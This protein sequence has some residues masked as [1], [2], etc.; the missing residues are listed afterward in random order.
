MTTRTK[1][2]AKFFLPPGTRRF[3][4]AKALA[5]KSRLLSPPPPDLKYHEW[6]KQTEPFLWTKQ[7]DLENKPLISIIVP[8]FNSPARYLL[9]MVYSVV[10][11]KYS[12]WELILINASTNKKAANLTR[13]CMQIDKRI[14]VFDTSN[15][16]GIVGN[17]N[18]GLSHC[19]GKYVGL[20]DHDDTLSPEALY[21]VACLLQTQ[22]N[23]QMIYS[24]EDKITEDGE[25]RFD[26][27][28]KPDWSPTL[29]K[30]V[31]YMNHFMV[32]EKKLIDEVGGLRFGFDGAQDYDLY[33]RIIDKKVRVAHV[34]KI[35]YHWRAAHNSTAFNFAI[36]KD[37]QKAGARAV[38]EHLKRNGQKGKAYYRPNLP[39][40]YDT[41]YEPEKGVKAALLLLPGE[42]NEQYAHLV[43]QI[44]RNTEIKIPIDVFVAE[45]AYLTS[46][47]TKLRRPNPV[48]I[49]KIQNKNGFI[50]NALKH[51]NAN[52]VILI[53]CA[54]LPRTGGWIKKICGILTQN[55]G[56]GAIAPILLAPGSD[57]ILEAGFIKSDGQLINP[58]QNTPMLAHTYIGHPIWARDVE[59]LSG[60]VLAARRD[61]F[62]KY[63]GDQTFAG[64][65]RPYNV[66]VYD[67]L[68]N[69]G[70]SL[71]V[72][73]QIQMEFFGELSP[74][75]PKTHFFNPNLGLHHEIEIPK[76]YYL[77]RKDEN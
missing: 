35:L 74:D 31:N 68:R 67:K 15:D 3:K 22:E 16:K 12:N 9:P 10:N 36:K 19:T 62:E 72:F 1:N 17:T 29:I 42:K 28:F 57:I 43:G 39:G 51:T 33:L 58:F 52:I 56:L 8:V 26:V 5:I 44:L 70:L 61:I 25:Y 23:P 60:Q 49:I 30:Q 24:D 59:Y 14:R 53:N 34:P 64:T 73:P 27:F 69:D 11:Q 55:R 4:L 54:A 65:T 32:M 20:L 2:L 76:N 50:R 18:L 45:T 48:K 75:R 37:I 63:F 13:T 41:I 71:A 38:N 47:I 7:T 40:F 6:T 77:H 46:A 21:E 66:E